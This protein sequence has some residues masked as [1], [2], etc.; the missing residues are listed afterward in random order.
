MLKNYLKIA[1]RN[2]VKFKITSFINISG[3]AIGIA[4]FILIFS[5]FYNEITY[6]TFNK[7]YKNIYRI[8]TVE[9]TPQ[10]IEKVARTP[11]PLAATLRNDFPSL[12]AVSVSD[13]GIE[14]PV[15]R[16]GR[17]FKEKIYEADPGFFSFFT[18][19]FLLG[20]PRTALSNPSSVV[21]TKE[22]AEKY[23]GKKDPIGKTIILFNRYPLMI[24]GVLKKIPTNSSIQLNL[25]VSTAFRKHFIPGYK[26]QWWSEGRN[27]F[28]KCTNNFTPAELRNI[29]VKTKDKY[30]QGFLKDRENFDIQPL[31]SVHLRPEIIGGIVPPVSSLYL[32]AL[33]AIAL[34]IILIA[35]INFT[36]L[37][38][39]KSTDRLKE[40]NVRR[41]L[42]SK[43]SQLIFQLLSESTLLSFTAL[44]IG[45]ALAELFLPEFNSL[46]GKN[47]ELFQFNLSSI[48]YSLS[49]GLFIGI[50]SGLYPAFL[51]S[52]PGL[53]ESSRDNK[54][55]GG[56]INIFRKLLLTAQF[57]IST[58]L[59][60]CI[61]V[62]GRQIHFMKNFNLGFNKE[63]VLVISLNNGSGNIGAKVKTFENI[64][65]NNK[66]SA[67][68]ISAAISENTPGYYYNNQFGVIPEGFDKSQ[69]I[70]MVVTSAD[71]NFLSTYK[72]PI[73]AGRNFSK[74]FSSDTS[75]AVLINET[76]LKKIGWNSA[77]GK[78]ITFSQ[79]DGPYK[80]IG[81]VKDFNY[82]SLQN[83]IEPLVIRYAG[84][85]YLQN[86][87][88]VR[89]N[90]SNIYHSVNYLEKEWKELFP[91][92]QFDYFFV[93]NKY[94]AAY[95]A[96]GRTEEIISTFSFIAIMLA[97]L[98][99][100]GL[101]ILTLTHKTK[102]I[103]IRKVLGASV[104]SIFLLVSKQFI[105]IILIA[106][107]LAVPVAYLFMHEWLMNY[108]YRIKLDVSFFL[109]SG[110]IVLLIAL[111]TISIQV[112]KAAMENPV[113]AL[114]Y[115]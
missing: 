115:E 48:I 106:D 30:L 103:G 66:Q 39:S 54:S 71:E 1:F 9:K 25:V 81:V 41:V 99:L 84:F 22:L 90:S 23:F 42:G 78:T 11:D 114:R 61:L 12:S 69:S 83:K 37:S 89:I 64:I 107:L 55:P 40:I 26:E 105:E 60:T 82:K 33:L 3:L 47:L 13:E 38:V 77:V 110:L 67:G 19:P 53:I 62:V 76:A 36:N 74:E 52:S 50:I 8:Y 63:N 10:G 79:G 15:R 58:I 32:Y 86:F 51:L 44:L 98:G 56:R 2:L 65:K 94:D 108:P 45:I 7:D 4:C 70:T 109:L 17:T 27:T 95:R 49:F 72:I 91:S 29:L 5:Y 93:D 80:I 31:T 68:I 75:E 43:K 111:L 92:R 24:S 35:C 73:I 96:E 113:K 104:K 6:D 59:I 57:A 21:I 112:I 14:F 20:N 34:S 88:S 97:S 85:A 102:E 16:N 18:F 46:T 28:V 101:T 87:L 100:L